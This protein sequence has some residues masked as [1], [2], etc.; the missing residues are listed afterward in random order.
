MIRLLIATVL[1]V[2]AFA[3]CDAEFEWVEGICMDDEVVV[4]FEEG[5]GF[6]RAGKE[7]DPDCPEGEIPREQRPAREIDCIPN[8]ISQEPS[9]GE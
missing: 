5:G 4:Q 8:D 6:C 7:T 2:P 3:A 9:Y 1:L